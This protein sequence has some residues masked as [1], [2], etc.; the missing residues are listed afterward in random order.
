[1]ARSRSRSFGRGGLIRRIGLSNIS[2]GQFAEGE[3]IAK[4]VCVQNHYNLAHRLRTARLRYVQTL[5]LGL[6]L[7]SSARSSAKGFVGSP[8]RQKGW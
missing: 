6:A 5:R 7:I 2:G 4:I 3:K 8:C 1:M